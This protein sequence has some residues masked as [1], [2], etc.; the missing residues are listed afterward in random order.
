MA[1]ALTALRDYTAVR[2]AVML[3]TCGR[4]EIYAE[5]EDYETGVAQMKSFLQNFRPGEVA[6]FESYLYTLLG[7]EAGEHLLGVSTGL[8]S[9]PIGEGEIM[10]QVKEA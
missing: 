6:D 7:R 2:E 8:S 9:M 5:L 10:G 1:E 4:L 3:S